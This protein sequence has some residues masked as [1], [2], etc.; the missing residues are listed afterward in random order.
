MTAPA[1]KDAPSFA[2]TLLW[3]ALLVVGL[4]A[5]C[6]GALMLSGGDDWEPTENEA[7]SVCE[8]WVED[9]LKS[10]ATADFSGVSTRAVGGQYEVAGQVD[11]ENGFGATV[12]T[13]WTCAVRYDTATE[14]WRGSA[15]LG[16]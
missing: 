8:G 4:P 11:A 5:A 15:R 13:A 14:E 2:K 12:R 7:R 6:T 1:E 3:L 16:P 10:P 9:R